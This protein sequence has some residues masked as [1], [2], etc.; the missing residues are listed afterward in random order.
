MIRASGIVGSFLLQSIGCGAE[1]IPTVT[2]IVGALVIGSAALLSTFEKTE[3]GDWMNKKLELCW[4]GIKLV[5]SKGS[6]RQS[7]E[8]IEADQSSNV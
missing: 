6:K 3:K 1:P 5:C 8:Q 4:S 7:D 2:S